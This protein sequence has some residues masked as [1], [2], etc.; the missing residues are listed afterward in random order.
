MVIRKLPLTIS[1]GFLGL[2]LQERV[3]VSKF[4]F[5]VC[6]RCTKTK[7]LS[8]LLHDKIIKN[9]PDVV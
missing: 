9:R 3:E 2:Q 1:S 7:R 6:N 8:Y 5:D 4:Q